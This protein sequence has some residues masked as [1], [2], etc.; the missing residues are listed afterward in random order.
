MAFLRELINII[1]FELDESKFATVN[2]RIGTA[3]DQLTNRGSAIGNLLQSVAIPSFGVAAVHAFEEW[4]V[5]IAEVRQRLISTGNTANFTAEELDSM[6]QKLAVGTKFYH[7]NILE[8]EGALLKFQ[9]IAGDI[10]EQVTRNAIDFAAA[11]KIDVV[12]SI[13]T[14]GRILQGSGE[15]LMVLER[16]GINFTKQEKEMM[17]NLVETGRQAEYQQF[18]LG[19]LEKA[20]GGSAQAIAKAG[21]GITGFK[22]MLHEVSEEFGKILFPYFKAFYKFMADI[23]EKVVNLSPAIKNFIVALSAVASAVFG[24]IALW[25]LLKGIVMLFNPWVLAIVAIGIALALLIDDMRAW[26]KGNDSFL[27]SVLGSWKNFVRQLQ[28]FFAPFVDIILSIWESIKGI[29]IAGIHNIKALFSGNDA[30]LK[31]GMKEFLGYLAGFIDGLI[32]L[33]IMSIVKGA[34]LLY[35]ILYTLADIIRT[36]LLTALRSVLSSLWELVLSFVKAAVDKVSSFF[37]SPI[38]Q[39]IGKF[40]GGAGRELSAFVSNAGGA[41]VSTS[42]LAPSPAVVNRSVNQGNKVVSLQV[43]QTVP[44]GTKKD[45]ADFIKK[46]TQDTFREHFNILLRSALAN[47]PEIP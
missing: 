12:S 31:K 34:P 44:A 7:D 23:L 36:L 20:Y 9:G 38:F 35:K 5:A 28:I 27:G 25:P 18:I 6:S 19:R 26:V 40:L 43:N 41:G 2:R 21:V 15:R 14:L 30:D 8:A 10:Y 39:S 46:T 16:A 11:N 47:A 13:Q 22:K 4:N 3:F 37:T 33:I 45:Q 24:I 32:N 42:S 29:F 1:G 17:K